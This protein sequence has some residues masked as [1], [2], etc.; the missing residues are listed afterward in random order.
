MAWV[1]G[2][3]G[4]RRPVELPRGTSVDWWCGKISEAGRALRGD[5]AMG[6]WGSADAPFPQASAAELEKA[7]FHSRNAPWS[8]SPRASI[9]S[10]QPEVEPSTPRFNGP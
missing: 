9:D 10:P 2:V 8:S 3:L 4:R 1:Q 7:S 6:G 5:L